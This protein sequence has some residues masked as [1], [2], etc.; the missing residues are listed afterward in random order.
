MCGTNRPAQRGQST[1]NP[2]PALMIRLRQLRNPFCR[3]AERGDR[4]ILNRAKHRAVA[5]G[6]QLFKCPNN[7]G[8]A[9]REA[10]APAGH[11]KGLGE[12]VGFHSPRLRAGL[13]EKA[14]RRVTGRAADGRIGK[15]VQDR[16]LVTVGK[17]QGAGEQRRRG[18]GAGG[19]MRIVKHHQP[20]LVS[21]LPG[22]VVKIR[23]EMVLS[24]ERQAIKRR[25]GLQRR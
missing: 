1:Q 21:H 5:V 11:I 9:D 14:Q 7:R 3:Q 13:R 24:P 25:L 6:V 20:G 23:Q 19:V 8:V 15:I 22:E 17:L 18:E 16:H 12:G 10:E 4:R 2:L